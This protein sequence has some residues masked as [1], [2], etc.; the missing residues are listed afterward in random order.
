MGSRTR[1]A[2]ATG[3]QLSSRTGGRYIP[4]AEA[5]ANGWTVDYVT[6]H[7]YVFILGSARQRRERRQMLRWPAQPYPKPLL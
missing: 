1:Y 5:R 4:V 2:D 6:R 3:A 7:R